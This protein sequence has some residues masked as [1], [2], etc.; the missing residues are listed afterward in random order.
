MGMRAAFI[1]TQKPD[2]LLPH[3]VNGVA[4]TKRKRGSRYEPKTEKAVVNH[5]LTTALPFLAE[6]TG[7][8]FTLH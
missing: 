4:P 5:R 6:R 2:L 3:E 7:N 8:S 1:A